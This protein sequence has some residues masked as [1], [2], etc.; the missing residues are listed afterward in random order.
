[1]NNA[2]YWARRFKIMEDALKDQ[3]Y[4]YVKNLEQ[5]FDNAIAQIDTQMRAWYQRFADNNGGITFADAQK[6][7]TSGELKEFKWTVQQYIK[8]GKEHAISGA[9]EKELENAS[10]RVHISRLESLKIQLRQLAESLT[11]ARVTAT[12]NASELSY[13]QSYYH[14]AFEVQRGLGVGW[15]MQALDT[16]TV[17]K[18]LSRPWTV[19]NQTF[20]ARCWTDKTKLVETVNQELTR[21]LVTGEAPDKAIAA[22]T[23]RFGVSKS[24]AGR[25]VMTESAYFSSAAQKDCFNDLGVEQYRIIG[26]LDTKTCNICGDMDGEVF[27]M[28]EYSPGSTAPPFHP[29]CRCCTAPYFEDMEGLGERFAR[30]VT[31]GKRYKLPKDTTY[32]QWKEMQDAAH[33]AGTV[34]KMRKMEYNKSADKLQFEAYKSR[35]GA[36]APK[37]FEAFQKLKYDN[38]TAYEGISGYYRYKGNNPDSNK[39]LYKANNAVKAMR[40]AGTIK[41]KGTITAAP[42]G[43]SIVGINTHAAKRMAERGITQETAQHIID[44][45]DFAIKQRKGTQYAYYTKDGFAVLDNNG[46]LGTTGPLDEG[47]KKL[48]DEVMKNAGNSK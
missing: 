12:T 48:Y 13:T 6:L 45:A 1:M 26:T 22:I 10:A 34:D 14:T 42:K 36:D 3:S 21:M 7:L 39:G 28:S 4:E 18:V 32:K 41:T 5:Q 19:D 2:D 20:T 27:K 38:P 40:A 25:V 31:T 37:T 23:K 47:G 9:W 30:D 11:N 46:V 43:R 15:T 8:A 33:G 17:Q 44:N 29:W 16:G 24:N 35:L